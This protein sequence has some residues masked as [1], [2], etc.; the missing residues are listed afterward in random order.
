MDDRALPDELYEGAAR[1]AQSGL[2][3]RLEGDSSVYLLHIATALE[4][5]AKAF[6]ASLDGALVAAH[7]FDSLLHGSGHSRHARKPRARMRTITMREALDRV[8]QVMPAIENL[9]GSL[10]L[11][12]DVRNGVVHAGQLDEGSVDAVLVPF[13]RG[14]DH[15]L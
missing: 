5:L 4:L 2:R 7:D 1:F 9:K 15:L 13:L 3:A 11:L 10:Q 14:C 8:G 12:A 6:L